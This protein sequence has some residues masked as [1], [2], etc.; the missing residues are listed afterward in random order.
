MDIRRTRT[1]ERC[2]NAVSVDKVKIIPKTKDVTMLVCDACCEEIRSTPQ[3]RITE[4]QSRIYAELPKTK[5]TNVP[6]STPFKSAPTTIFR[7]SN[8]NRTVPLPTPDYAKYTCVKCN[9]V[10]RVDRVKAGVTYGVKCPYCG[11]S[12]K[13]KLYRQ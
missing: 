9:Y 13:L 10:F 3:A 6:G 5:I 2:K 1:C 11:R 8:N 7:P 12:D 4:G